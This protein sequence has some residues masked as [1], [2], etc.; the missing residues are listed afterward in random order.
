MGIY[1]CPHIFEL[2]ELPPTP[3]DLVHTAIDEV[4]VWRSSQ[5]QFEPSDTLFYI[6]T[7][8]ERLGL[9]DYAVKRIFDACEEPLVYDVDTQMI[10]NM[11]NALEAIEGSLDDAEENGP[12]PPDEFGGECEVEHHFARP[13]ATT[14]NL[15]LML[16]MC[17]LAVIAPVTADDNDDAEIHMTLQLWAL[18]H[19]GAIFICQSLIML[20]IIIFIVKLYNKAIYEKQNKEIDE[21]RINQLVLRPIILKGPKCTLPYV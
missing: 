16:G 10:L 17:L 14:S 15:G 1:S 21:N 5:N 18:Q 7:V 12:P 8:C 3:C 11:D 13:R 6:E 4:E 2:F 20:G 9:D 19:I